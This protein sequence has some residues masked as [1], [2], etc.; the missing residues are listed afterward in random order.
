MSN[1]LYSPY[2]VTAIIYKFTFDHVHLCNAFIE[3]RELWIS[4]DT[5]NGDDV[6]RRSS[7][8]SS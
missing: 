6:L 1:P 8:N 3:D 7:D 4:D 2:K 5:V